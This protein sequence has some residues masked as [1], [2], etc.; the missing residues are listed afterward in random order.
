MEKILSGSRPKKELTNSCQIYL[1][2]PSFALS[3]A[4]L[5]AAYITAGCKPNTDRY[6]CFSPIFIKEKL[7]FG[8]LSVRE[9]R[10]FV[11]AKWHN[12]NFQNAEGIPVIEKAEK[13]YL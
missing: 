10:Y 8:L 9:N 7:L 11:K 5:W 4:P 12:A 3:V 13:S 2:T 6:F 1:I